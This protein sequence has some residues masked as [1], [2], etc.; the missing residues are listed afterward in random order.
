MEKCSYYMQNNALREIDIEKL[1]CLVVSNCTN[2][3]SGMNIL[4]YRHNL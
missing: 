1:F 3:I 4:I 2:L